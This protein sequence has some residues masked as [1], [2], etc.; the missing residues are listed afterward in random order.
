MQSKRKGDIILELNNEK[1]TAQNT[2]AKMIAKYSPG[3]KI[4]LKI[5]R[6]ASPVGGLLISR[7]A[8]SSRP[9]GNFQ[10]PISNTYY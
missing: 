1:I 6:P 7:S 3:E 9:K 5:L 8:L 4:T 2:L 10:K